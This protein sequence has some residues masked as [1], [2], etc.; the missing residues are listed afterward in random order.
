M[1]PK[2]LFVDKHRYM[3]DFLREDLPL[4]EGEIFHVKSMDEYQKWISYLTPDILV[5]DMGLS[6]HN[7]GTIISDIKENHPRLPIILTSIFEKVMEEPAV[8]MADGFVLKKANTTQL[9]KKIL[10]LLPRDG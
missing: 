6:N 5:L 3:A 8:R 2:I 10:E 4:R 9:R 1:K 7:T